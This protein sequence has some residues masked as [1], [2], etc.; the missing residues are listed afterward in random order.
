MAYGFI[1]ISYLPVKP[2]DKKQQDRKHIKDHD[3]KKR[4]AKN[5]YHSHQ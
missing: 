1:K 3:P 5:K 4:Q 2:D